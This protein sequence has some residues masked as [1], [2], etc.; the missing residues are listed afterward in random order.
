[1]ADAMSVKRRRHRRLAIGAIT[2]TLVA[3]GIFIAFDDITGRIVEPA[4]T[5]STSVAQRMLSADEQAF[6]SFVSP[7]LATISAESDR[8][9]QLA[10]GRSRN[11]LELQTRGGRI[12]EGARAI[13]G[14]VSDHGVPPRFDEAFTQYR[15]GIG[16]I[17]YGIGEARSGFLN[18]DWDRVAGAV[19]E[20]SEGAADLSHAFETLQAAGGSSPLNTSTPEPTVQ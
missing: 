19:D 11:L 14:Y 2:M 10:E 17:R 8:L 16:A 6:Y 18:F 4:P 7:R 1:M 15:R 9:V 12:D 3:L 5:K 13:D 20:F